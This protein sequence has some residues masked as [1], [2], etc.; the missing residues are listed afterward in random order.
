MKYA[1]AVAIIAAAAASD[2]WSGVYTDAQAK[3]GDTIYADKC[4]SC[5][6]PDLTGIDQAPPLTGSD[7]MGN[8][9]DLSMHDL[10]ERVR[11]SMPADKPGTLTPQE[12]ADVL[13]FVL[14]KNSL[15]AASAELATDAD[16]LKA[17]KFLAKKP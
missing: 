9:N 17:I 6:A 7:F 11:I 13:A 10:A 5:H 3:R 16:A 4:A 1:I 8:W 15:P 2:I 14:Q 12:V